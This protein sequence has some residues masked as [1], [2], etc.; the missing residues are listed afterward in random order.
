VTRTT[1]LITHR[2]AGQL[3]FSDGQTL[4]CDLVLSIHIHA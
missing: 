2:H 4:N 1:G 3:I